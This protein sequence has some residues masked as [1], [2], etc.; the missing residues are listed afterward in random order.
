MKC[1]G[2][3]CFSP[4]F[5]N[6]AHENVIELK[7][8]FDGPGGAGKASWTVTLPYATSLR[9][10]SGSGAMHV[11]NLQGEVDISGG[12]G[13]VQVIECR[14][15]VSVNAGSGRVE[16]EGVEGDL[17]VNNGSGK[18]TGQNIRG[19]IR[20]NSGSGRIDFTNIVGA[21]HLTAGSGNI[22]I[23]GAVVSGPGSLNAGSGDIKLNLADT[24]EYDLQLSSGSG[25]AILSYNGHPITGNFEFVAR[26]DRG[27]IASP[28]LFEEE[29]TFTK[30]SKT[31]LRKSFVRNESNPQITIETG[32]GTAR[33]NK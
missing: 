20:I 1:T 10:S 13:A 29:T 2:S 7:E 3:C 22:L 14:S 9:C 32:T 19:D 25:K 5:L 18:T 6:I 23:S 17:Q 11:E 12:S 26:E 33:L 4:D 30:N 15:R 8:N 27:R 21:F 28:F 24:A 16:I 31:Y